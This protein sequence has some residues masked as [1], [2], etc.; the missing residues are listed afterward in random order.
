MLVVQTGAADGDVVP[1]DRKTVDVA[2]RAGAPDKYADLIA[3]VII[4]RGVQINTGL[5]ALDVTIEAASLLRLG[6]LLTSTFEVL[7]L[8]KSAIR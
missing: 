7:W 1:A 6:D 5:D 2:L 3:R 8:N 4:G